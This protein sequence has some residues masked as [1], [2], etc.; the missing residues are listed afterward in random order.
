MY[1]AVLVNQLNDY[2]RMAV[3]YLKQTIYMQ[4]EYQINTRRMC[5]SLKCKIKG[6]V[7]VKTKTRDSV[8]G[9]SEPSLHQYEERIPAIPAAPR[10]VPE[11]EPDFHTPSH[12]SFCYANKCKKGD[13]RGDLCFSDTA[14][15]SGI[16]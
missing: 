9:N 6:V 13:C 7:E 1:N 16:S 2:Y 8:P 10:N 4:S 12:S 11:L 15:A 5:F 3:E 14:I